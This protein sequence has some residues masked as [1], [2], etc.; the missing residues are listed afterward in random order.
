MKLERILLA[1]DFSPPARAAEDYAMS[2]ASDWSARLTVMTVLEFPPGMDPEYPLN[3]HYLTQRM[4]EAT[5]EL[6]ELK[7]RSLRRRIQVGTRI[8]TGIPSLEIN[9]AAEEE[10]SDLIVVGT[11]GKSGLA[12]VL[13]G[14]T[15][16]RVI[17]TARCPVLGCA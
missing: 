2:L 6:A 12:H 1:T 8:A 11:R 4:S 13:L 9:Q 5:D 7:Q 15:A 14:S 3:Q 17:R 16:E 10:D